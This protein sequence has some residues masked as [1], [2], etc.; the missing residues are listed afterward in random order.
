M[1]NKILIL[2]FSFDVTTRSRIIIRKLNTILTS[3]VLFGKICEI[4][5]IELEKISAT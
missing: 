5:K 4:V 3:P 1:L 2:W